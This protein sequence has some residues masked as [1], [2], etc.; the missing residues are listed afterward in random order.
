MIC[1]ACRSAL[2]FFPFGEA[3]SSPQIPDAS[4]DFR[5]LSE[6]PQDGFS[7]GGFAASGFAD[8]RERLI[9]PQRDINPVHRVNIVFIRA[10]EFPS[11]RE[12][13]AEPFRFKKRPA[14][15]AF[16]GSGG[17]SSVRVFSE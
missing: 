7:R 14:G 1:A 3:V 8:Q 10:E 15:A 17:S 2:R 9:L 13:D 11:F 12:P 6:K 5:F 4:R 16:G